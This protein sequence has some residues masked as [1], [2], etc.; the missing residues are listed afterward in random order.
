MRV[1]SFEDQFDAFLQQQK[2]EASSRRLEMLERDLSGTIKMFREALWPIFQTFEGF[3]LEYELVLPNGV[4]FFIDVFY[5]PFRFGF[6]CEGFSA[7]AETISRDRFSFEKARIRHML[8]S[9]C[10]YIPFSWDELDKKGLQCRDFVC[11]LLRGYNDLNTLNST[12]TPYEREAIRC[13]LNLSRPVS[14]RDLC[15]SLGR[16]KDYVNKMIGSLL[17]KS[18]FQLTNVAYKRNRTFIVS[19]NA[20]DLIR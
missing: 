7:H 11:E 8:L 6:E 14:V 10:V 20:V 13:A 16:K 17:E 9:G 19:Q 12:L 15:K 4:H 2:K 5:A 18:V 1:F 3:I